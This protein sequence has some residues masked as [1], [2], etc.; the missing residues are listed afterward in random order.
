MLTAWK[1]VF[2]DCLWEAGSFLHEN[3]SVSYVTGLIICI[4]EM[5][6]DLVSET[7][8]FRSECSASSPV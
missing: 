6:C 2:Y 5:T 3:Q 8:Y 1:Y 7:K 4:T